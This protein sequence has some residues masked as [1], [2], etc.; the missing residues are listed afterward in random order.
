MIFVIIHVMI[1]WA[2]SRSDAFCNSASHKMGKTA[3]KIESETILLRR[4]KYT[5]NLYACIIWIYC[6][7]CFCQCCT[8]I[9][10]YWPRKGRRKELTPYRSS[11]CPDSGPRTWPLCVGFLVS[12]RGCDSQED[13]RQVPGRALGEVDPKLVAGSSSWPL[14]TLSRLS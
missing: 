8:C 11:S 13:I 6:T 5:R 12:R 2:W 4:L 3:W 10:S 14:L 9:K 1:P 7:V